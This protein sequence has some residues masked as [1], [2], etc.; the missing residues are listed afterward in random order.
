MS[1]YVYAIQQ[2]IDAE[3]NLI[4]SSTAWPA[5]KVNVADRAYFRTFR[6]DPYSPDILIEPLHSRISGEWTIH[7]DCPAGDSVCTSDWVV[8]CAARP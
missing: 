5:P 7:P 1:S 3:G 8:G 4:N 2:S 6:Y